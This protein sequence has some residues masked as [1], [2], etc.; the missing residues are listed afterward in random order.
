L[1]DGLKV[2][3][4]VR[5]NLGCGI[6]VLP[7]YDNYDKVHCLIDDRV[8]FIDLE[9]LPLPFDDSSIDE[10]HMTNTFEHLH[11]N[12]HLFMLEVHRVLKPG[13]F[14]FI[15]IPSWSN[16]VTHE[17]PWHTKSYFDSLMTVGR[18]GYT[19]KALFDVERVVDR[20]RP[21]LRL[22]LVRFLGLLRD[23]SHQEWDYTIRKVK[24]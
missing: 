16:Y 14:I 19:D 7:G 10:I 15:R 9:K 6:N 4:V 18:S 21:S 22:L 11:V 23:M 2:V 3:D 12:Q 8:K 17:S 5:V 24:Q 1:S 20:H 13:G